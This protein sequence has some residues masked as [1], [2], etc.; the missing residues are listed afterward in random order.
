MSGMFDK[1]KVPSWS[2]RNPLGIIALF[3]SLIYGMSALL[4]GTSIDSLAAHNQV[5]LVVFVVLFPFAVLGVFVW[6]VAKHHTKLYGPGDYKSDQGFL[7]VNT[8]DNPASLGERL[9]KDFKEQELGQPE[10]DEFKRDQEGPVTDTT[11]SP[12]EQAVGRDHST[13]N[14]QRWELMSQAY[15]AESLVF[16]ELQNELGGTVRR[17]VVLRAS[18]GEKLEADGIIESAGAVFIVEVKLL[19]T[20]PSHDELILRN[21]SRQAL[22]YEQLLQ[23]DGSENIRVLMAVVIS[24][25]VADLE[26]SSDFLRKS[27]SAKSAR[28][29]IRVFSYE[30]LLRKYGLPSDPTDRRIDPRTLLR[31]PR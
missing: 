8:I 24:E 21:M 27:E 23:Q 19:L 7:D 25:A 5:I 9:E 26:W 14:R 13:R 28:S 15:I 11:D 6:L 16:Q 29:I 18:T 1:L 30:E 20:R 3:I 17:Q 12:N 4:L 2:A 22:N 31:D 10:S